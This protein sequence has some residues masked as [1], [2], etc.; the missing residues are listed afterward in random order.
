M[1]EPTWSI[2]EPGEIEFS[3]PVYVV[4]ESIG[5]FEVSVDRKN[6][7][8]G[9]VSVA[10]KTTDINA[11]ADK[12]YIRKPIWNSFLMN[13]S[14]KLKLN[15]TDFT[16]K[17]GTLEFKHGEI[18]KTIPITIIDD[19]TA[20]KDESF[21]LELFDAK[22]GVKLGRVWKTVVTIINDDGKA[23]ITWV[24]SLHAYGS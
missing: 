1:L 14:R 16:A 8:D 6:G 12:D 19:K 10:F 7:A 3:Q 11:V 9:V 5:T 17:N 18:T 4:K 2:S 24:R 23:L 21:S 13:R 20:E 22:G 15:F